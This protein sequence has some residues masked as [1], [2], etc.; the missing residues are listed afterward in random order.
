MDF[1]S[2]FYYNLFFVVIIFGNLLFK[3]LKYAKITNQ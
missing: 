2:Y 3:Q 1:T